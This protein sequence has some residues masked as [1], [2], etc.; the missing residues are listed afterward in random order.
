MR[1]LVARCDELI[2]TLSLRPGPGI[3]LAPLH[4][5]LG[6]CRQA[7]AAAPGDIPMS[8]L[9]G[10]FLLLAIGLFVYLLVALLRASGG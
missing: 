3:D 7:A 2:F 8:V 6:E 5:G 4:P 10:L 9:D 1:P